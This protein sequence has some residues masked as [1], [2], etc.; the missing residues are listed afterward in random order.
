MSVEFSDLYP[1]GPDGTFTP[2]TVQ[3]G[4][5]DADVQ[6]GPI[7]YVSDFDALREGQTMILWVQVFPADIDPANVNGYYVSLVRIKPWFVRSNVEDRTPGAVQHGAPGPGVLQ[8]PIPPNNRVKID[9]QTF[10]PGTGLIT[11]FQQPPPAPPGNTLGNRRL[12]IPSPKRLDTIPAIYGSGPLAI[13]VDPQNSDSILL[14][15]V[16]AIPMPDPTTVPAAFNVSGTFA[17]IGAI[18]EKVFHYPAHGR[19]LGVSVEY[20][21]TSRITATVASR[22]TPLPSGD[23]P[24]INIG[25]KTGTGTLLT[26]DR[27]DG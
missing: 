14:D 26:Q 19:A 21:L 17:N 12:W 3:V 16:W 25:Y 23:P 6:Y 9:A 20:Q 7:A 2:K 18:V 13:A 5:A 1:K 10:S 27:I 4:N 8:D 24:I 11:I 15:D 22:G